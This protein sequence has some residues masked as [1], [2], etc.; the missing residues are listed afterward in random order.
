MILEAVRG[1]GYTG[2]IA[3]DD[4]SFRDGACS[5]VPAAA[6]PSSVITTVPP[7]TT[8]TVTPSTGESKAIYG[9]IPVCQCPL[10]PETPLHTRF[11][12]RT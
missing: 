2:D 12:L 8:P 1:N 11:L 5:V 10:L 6:D 4:F 3:I 9:L 7:T